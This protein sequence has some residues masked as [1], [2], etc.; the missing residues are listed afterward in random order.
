MTELSPPS[1]A[2]WLEVVVTTPAHSG[3]G[4]SLTYWSEQP[5]P[6]G[7]LVRVPLGSRETLG[8]V[9]AE[10]DHPPAG[11]Q[12][13]QTRAV[14]QA[15][16]ACPPL[17][18]CW[19]ALVAFAARYYQRALGEVALAA[20][21]PAL[22]DLQPEQLARRLKKLEA[23]K[24]QALAPTDPPLPLSAEQAQVLEQLG[25]AEQPVL[26]FGTTGSGKTEVYLQAAQ[27]L[28]DQDPAAQVL[29]M[30]PEINLTPQ[31]EARFHARFGSHGVVSLHSGL[32]PAQR[33]KHWLMA[34]QG[35][36][37]IVL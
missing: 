2:I 24:S 15:L 18:P 25:R 9:W 32:T 22:R 7:T 28:L 37:R 29:V 23:A 12:W 36:A 3:L 19:R 1:S 14:I 21:P 26:L 13:A 5:L 16:E 34:H 35:Q 31:L 11:Q 17:S 30:V 6:P 8:I 4:D 33:L 27:R 10:N 20:L